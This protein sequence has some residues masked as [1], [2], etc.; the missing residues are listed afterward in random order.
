MSVGQN[1]QDYNKRRIILLLLFVVVVSLL[2]WRVVYLQVYD[3]S[4]LQGQGTARYLRTVSTP[5][6]RGVIMDRNGDALAISTPVESIWVNPK[7]LVDHQRSLPTLAKILRLDLDSLKQTIA[8]R[9]N[10]EFVYLKR[11]VN[12]ELAEK[13]LALDIDGVFSQREYRRYYPAGE[14]V[15]HVIGFTNIDDKGQEGIELA[16]EDWLKGTPGKKRVIKDRLGRVI[17][18]VENIKYADA[19]KDLYLSVDRRIQYLAYRELKTA[20][21]L[22][23]ARSGSAVMLDVNSGEVLAIVNQPSY[24]PNNRRKLRSSQYRNRA[25]TDVFEPGSTIKP[26]TIAT[27]LESKKY[28]PSTRIDTSPG[29]LKIGR[30]TI[31][32]HKNYGEIDVTRVITKS[33]NVGA[34]KIALSLDA[35][36]IWSMFN[37]VG[38]GSVTASGFPG[39]SAGLMSH[40]SRWHKIERATLSFGYGLSVTP[41]QLA[42]AYSILASDGISRPVSFIKTDAEVAGEQVL[43]ARVARQVQKMMKTVVSAEGTGL[44]ADVYGY[45]VA[46]KTGTIHK[47]TAGGYANDRYIAV[48]AGMAPASNPRLVLVVMINDPAGE[49][50]YGG[51]VAAPVFSKVMSG[52]LRLMDIAPDNLPVLQ[53]HLKTQKDRS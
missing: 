23:K 4:F 8:A 53:T 3:K 33:S 1:N 43:P 49:K 27:A 51:Q 15:S 10:R 7:K 25:V 45:Q 12:P 26:F 5:A 41:L 29:R 40:Y 32:D 24:N 28:T 52:A 34:S 42:H 14:V 16:Y 39:E 38:F 22:N 11:H 2:M 48:F 31:R 21:K 47:S 30:N 20:I 50:Y 44:L 6:H 46:G 13:V 35:E 36:K 19:G 17:E 37:R 9:M 18:D